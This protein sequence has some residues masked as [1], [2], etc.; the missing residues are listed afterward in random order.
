MSVSTKMNF[1]DIDATRV[2]DSCTIIS[3]LLM[4]E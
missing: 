3:T 4:L 1:R 2:F